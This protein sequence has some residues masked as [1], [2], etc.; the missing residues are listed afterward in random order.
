MRARLERYVYYR[1]AETDLPEALMA[2]VSMQR[3]LVA[4]HPG[5]EALRLRRPGAADGFVTLM[6][7]YRAPGGIGMALERAIEAAAAVA[8]AGRL[9]GSRHLEDFEPL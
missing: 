8:L 1:V 4:A 2:V 6:E 9:V 3:R 5:L 7:V